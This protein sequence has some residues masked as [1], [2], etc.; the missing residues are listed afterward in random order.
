ML[1]VSEYFYLL[2]FQLF[3]RFARPFESNF[4]KNQEPRSHMSRHW[5]AILLGVLMLFA[6]A[7]LAQ[8]ITGSIV[9]TVRDQSGAVVPKATVTITNTDTGIVARTVTSSENGEY[10]VP[11]LAIGHYSVAAEASGF[12]KAT[13]S[14][15]QLHVNEK[16]TIDPRL[17]VGSSSESVNVEASALQIELQSATAS[18]LITGTQVREL[19]LNN[20]NYEQLVG[21]MPGVTYGGDDQLYIGT[22][23][24]NS[25]QSNQVRFAINGGRKSMN[26]WTVDG[27]DNV[28]R[29]ANLTLLTYPS[30]DAIAE[31]KVL[32]GLYSAEFG[33][34]GG[35]QVNVA[36]RSGGSR[37]HASAYE[38]VRNDALNANTFFS[39]MAQVSSGR[40]NIPPVL[41]YNDFGFT[42]GGPVFLPKVYNTEHNKTF[43]FVSEEFRRVITYVT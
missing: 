10:S 11:S 14:A 42:I 39:K 7:L 26:N 34:A 21:L 35:G 33:R 36:T 22:T 32:R 23:N 25:G 24:P 8:D 3:I 41:R 4:K 13:V 6:T 2:L 18:G 28:D 15:I 12:K 20:R 16:L 1:Q 31:F 40:P 30:V 27:A 38:F 43:F 5:K 9:G 19:S 37:F 17:Q 29:G